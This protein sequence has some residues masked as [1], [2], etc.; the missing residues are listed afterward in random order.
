VST[1]GESQVGTPR[2]TFAQIARH[3]GLDLDQ[4]QFF[5]DKTV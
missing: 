3:T 2:S 5:T 1:I 4:R